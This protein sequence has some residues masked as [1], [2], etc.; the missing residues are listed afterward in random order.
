M[1][2]C[3]VVPADAGVHGDKASQ[4]NHLIELAGPLNKL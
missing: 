1:M 4:M 3:D 2:P